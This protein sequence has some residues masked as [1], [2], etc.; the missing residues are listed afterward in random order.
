VSEVTLVWGVLDD[1]DHKCVS[2]GVVCDTF[3]HL[4]ASD[5]VL[6]AVREECRGKYTRDVVAMDHRT[7]E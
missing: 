7:C 3:D 5:A 1:R 6:G 2:E 4:L